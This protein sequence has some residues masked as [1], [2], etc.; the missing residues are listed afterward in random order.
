MALNQHPD[1]E[2]RVSAAKRAIREASVDGV[3]RRSVPAQLEVRAKSDGGYT[4][5]GHAAVFHDLS[6][7]LGGFRE[8]IDPGAFAKVLSGRPDTRALFNH[9]PNLVLART[10]NGTLRMSEDEIG[11]HYEADVADTTYGRDLKVLLER[12]DVTQSSFAFRVAA[13]GDEWLEDQETGGLIR[14]ISEFSQLFDV[15]PVTYPAY[16]TTDSGARTGSTVLEAGVIY[17]NTNGTSP[18]VTVTSGTHSSQTDEERN[19]SANA[20]EQGGM[21]SSDTERAED[22]PDTWR[23][24][25]R[26][27]ELRLRERAGRL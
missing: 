20:Q 21:A 3:Q 13:G 17:A 23:A 1:F 22:T 8:R 5:F 19:A 7:N 15:S 12:G 9:D 11:L 4:L 14:V 2:T 26:E 10:T 16:P 27:R 25:A 6:E 18:D 24:R